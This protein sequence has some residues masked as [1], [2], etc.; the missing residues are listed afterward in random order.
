MYLLGRITF[1]GPYLSPTRFHMS[2]PVPHRFSPVTHLFSTCPLTVFTCPPPVPHQFSLVPHL[3]SPVTRQFSPITHLSLTCVPPGYRRG[4][5]RNGVLSI[6][7]KDNSA[8]LIF[9]FAILVSLRMSMPFMCS[10]AARVHALHVFM[11]C[12]CSCAA[13]VHALYVFI[14]CTC[15]CPARVHALHVFMQC[16]CSCT[17]RVHALYVFMRYFVCLPSQKEVCVLDGIKGRNKRLSQS[18]PSD[19]SA[20]LRLSVITKPVITEPV[21]TEPVITEPVITEPIITEPV[22]TEPVITEPVITEPVIT[23][24][25]ITEPVITEPVITEP[26]ITEPVITTDAGCL[27]YKTKAIGTQAAQPT[28]GKLRTLG[29]STG[30]VAFIER[31]REG[32][33]RSK[34]HDNALR[35]TPAAHVTLRHPRRTRPLAWHAVMLI[36]PCT[37]NSPAM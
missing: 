28:E 11:R 23:E 19:L 33:I 25:V 12:T 30:L 1:L 5:G 15:S 34:S 20:S 6:Y 4:G 31:K 24:P 36:S 35:L 22:I 13:R 10:C 21:I 7:I 17:A 3:F 16:T 27:L 9:A 29:A 18:W 37:Q 2:P 8:I 32:K 14:H 26:V